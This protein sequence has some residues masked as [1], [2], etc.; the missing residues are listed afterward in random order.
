[1]V[2]NLLNF[3]PDWWD[4][5]AHFIK[6]FA[7]IDRLKSFDNYFTINSKLEA[8]LKIKND[9]RKVL[10]SRVRNIVGSAPFF[11]DKL[12]NPSVVEFF[13]TKQ[14]ITTYDANLIT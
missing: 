12:I 8:D 9:N 4:F 10:S 5:L 11:P 14:S 3:P 13:N 1:M 6:G 7:W 2:Y